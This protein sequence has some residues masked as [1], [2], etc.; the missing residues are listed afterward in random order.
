MMLPSKETD[1][2]A[3]GIPVKSRNP[4]VALIAI[5]LGAAAWVGLSNRHAEQGQDSGV[6]TEPK[7][8]AQQAAVPIPAIAS[9]SL[10]DTNPAHREAESPPP[11]NA[12]PQ[13]VRLPDDVLN[14]AD[15]A[16]SDPTLS[17]E[18]EYQIQR[19]IYAN[20]DALKFEIQPIKCRENSC[21]ILAKAREPGAGISAWA[22]VLNTMLKDLTNTPVLNPTTGMKL[23]A[24][25]LQRIQSTKGSVVTVIGFKK[26]SDGGTS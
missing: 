1:I 11:V 17:R 26:P 20:I 8:S 5:A 4:M 10:A 15:Q 7:S 13:T 9:S 6:P 12:A 3:G 16:D 18:I 2:E 24:A 22:P 14:F 25:E 19:S 23:G 21:Q